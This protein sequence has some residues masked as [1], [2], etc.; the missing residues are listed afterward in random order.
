MTILDKL[1]IKSIKIAL[2]VTMSLI[3]GNLFKLDSPYLTA[4]TAIIGI[5]STVYDSVSNAKDRILG[6]TIGILMGIVTITFLSNS[7]III[8]IGIFII[9]YACN[10]LNL[11]SSIVHASVIYLSI[12]LFPSPNYNAISIIVSTIIGVVITLIVNFTFSPF[13]INQNLYKSYN[14]LM[15]NID[16]LCRSLFTVPEQVKLKEFNSNIIAYKTLLK[17]YDNEYFKINDKRLDKKHMDILCENLNPISFF[18]YGVRELKE[19]N[20]NDYNVNRINSLLNLDI[21]FKD[22]QDSQSDSLLNFHVDV[23]LDHLERV[24]LCRS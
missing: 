22:Y 8:S 4:I 3:I 21:I 14:S 9:I 6:T 23:L 20:L 15:K 13:E 11:K 5:Q 10:L 17:A 16:E 2:A 24:F 18:I 1:G 7:F 19:N 12:M